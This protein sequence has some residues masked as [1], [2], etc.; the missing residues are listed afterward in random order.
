MGSV[1]RR[2]HLKAHDFPEASPPVVIVGA[3]LIP[4]LSPTLT[5]PVLP[6]LNE[7]CVPI[8]AY[9][10]I[11]ET[12]AV[13]ITHGISG[14]LSGQV[15]NETETARSLHIAVQ[16][17]D[18]SYNCRLATHFMGEDLCDRADIERRNRVNR[19]TEPTI[20]LESYNEGFV[21]MMVNRDHKK[22]RNLSEDMTDYEV[23]SMVESILNLKV[24]SD[25]SSGGND[26][27]NDIE[28]I[29]GMDE[30]ASKKWKPN[31]F[32]PPKQD[33]SEFL[34]TGYKLDFDEPSDTCVN[35]APIQAPK[36]YLS[37]Q[38]AY[39]FDRWFLARLKRLD[40][41]DVRLELHLWPTILKGFSVC[42]ISGPKSG[43][44][45]AFLIPL[46]YELDKPAA[47]M[48]SRFSTG[49]E[50]TSIGAIVMCSSTRQTYEIAQQAKRW[51]DIDV[52]A[53]RQT[54]RIVSLNS[55]NADKQYISLMNGCDILVS[56]PKP[57]LKAIQ[58]EI[59]DVSSTQYLIIDE[60]D[61]CLKVHVNAIKDIYIAFAKSKGQMR[62]S[63]DGKGM[64]DNLM[65]FQTMA[66]ARKWTQGVEWFAKEIQH[67]PVVTF[68]SY[69]ELSI[70]FKIECNV[71]VITADG[72]REDT[73]LRVI[74]KAIDS[75]KSRIAVV[76]RTIDEIKFLKRRLMT[77]WTCVVVTHETKHY[78]LE[79]LCNK[80]RTGTVL[81]VNDSA[82]RQI[83]SGFKKCQCLIHYK[84][85]NDFK[86]T[87]GDRFRL[88]RGWLKKY[89][90][91]IGATN[92]RRLSQYILIG[93]D[94]SGHE[95]QLIRYLKRL[96]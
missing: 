94:D 41:R 56:T 45:N 82:I 33:L 14:R 64:G 55:S 71:E 37:C 9:N 91:P 79:Q 70:A 24:E 69:Y 96:K 46:M 16:T 92:A 68:G 38:K 58:D 32:L 95:P 18:H 63:K 88:M 78:D 12:R 77:K 5:P 66:F 74:Q 49:S 86:E 26:S 7:T 52:S 90:T 57:L 19:S 43:K 35:Y 50:R 67:M 10:P 21:D 48:D 28:E 83:S 61:V 8:R 72:N 4:H 85:P 3:V 39:G 73:V 89:E 1:D 75:N 11:V 47:H 29:D 30:E 6:A 60:A 22:G 42:C 93:D 59:I 87:F 51:R 27:D 17:D 36:G 53:G 81:L 25:H 20:P 80:W 23:E 40:C 2:A 15:F 13:H 44:T 76:C 54:V 65:A 84:L 62:L 34:D 31:V